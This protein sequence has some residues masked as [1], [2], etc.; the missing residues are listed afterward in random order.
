[1]NL[2]EYDPTTF[3]PRDSP[4][5]KFFQA[6]LTNKDGFET[7]VK[8]NNLISS[9]RRGGVTL[10][11]CVVVV[12]K[13]FYRNG[14]LVHQ[15]DVKQSCEAEQQFTQAAPF[16]DSASSAEQY[17]AKF[18]Q[19]I[20]MN[21]P[22][23]EEA[24]P[25][26]PKNYF[27]R[28]NFTA[29]QKIVTL[30]DLESKQLSSTATGV[31]KIT[32]D[33]KKGSEDLWD[34]IKSIYHSFKGMF[35]IISKKMNSKDDQISADW[36]AINTSL[37]KVKQYIF[38][39]DLKKASNVWE[40]EFGPAVE[41][42]G[43]DINKLY[44]G[45][46]DKFNNVMKMK[47]S[48]LGNQLLR[49]LEHFGGWVGDISQ[50]VWR[51][52]GSAI[53]DIVSGVTGKPGNRE[54]RAFDSVMGIK[55][56]TRTKDDSASDNGGNYDISLTDVKIVR[57]LVDA[58][59]LVRKN[60]SKSVF[61]N[62]KLFLKG[63]SSGPLLNLDSFKANQAKITPFTSKDIT[64]SFM[65]TTTGQKLNKIDLENY[66][67]THIGRSSSRKLK[68]TAGLVDLE[69]FGQASS[70]TPQKIKI[71]AYDMFTKEPLRNYNLILRE[72]WSKKSGEQIKNHYQD[73]TSATTDL[74]IPFGYYL[75]TLSKD[76]YDSQ[77]IK[78]KFSKNG[79]IYPFY[80]KRSNIQGELI[81][82]NWND[83]SKDFN[84]NSKLENVKTGEICSVNAENEFCPTAMFIRDR[85]LGDAGYEYI[86]MMPSL[87]WKI[88][89]YAYT[90]KV[91][92]RNRDR[93]L[94]SLD[95]L[96]DL[97]NSEYQNKV[98]R[99]KAKF[100]SQKAD[101]VKKYNRQIND[102]KIENQSKVARLKKDNKSVNK[103]ID[104]KIDD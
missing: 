84:L 96:V 22:N 81:V 90:N 78:I 18:D 64:L 69:S 35:Q 73:L 99:L 16:E 43:G 45:V 2:V 97:G 3:P 21:L 29:N 48:N 26:N 67:S 86:F 33:V 92:V 55:P 12:S 72:T 98:N 9:N 49:V 63:E 1:M 42:Q 104:D 66:K 34:D 50:D 59:N 47:G 54:E 100:D 58:K 95:G 89:T 36:K 46:T 39:G 11:S 53:G 4:D 27:R 70:Q 68:V 44:Q 28:T 24:A 51:S 5:F 102:W 23:N 94:E 77:D 76:T 15:K 32:E 7:P 93:K 17:F 56:D 41:K 80:L 101:E 103:E 6:Y 91:A 10:S 31:K 20:Q 88:M 71:Q 82:M 25:L 83:S 79:Q 13:K 19:M 75:L 74:E 40:T 52:M 61:I 85:K 65:D 30:V 37:E 87:D 14:K 57:T 60:V 8:S 62:D 38:N